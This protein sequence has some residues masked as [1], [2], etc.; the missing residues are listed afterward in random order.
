MKRYSSQNT[1]QVLKGWKITSD[2]C[3]KNQSA[4][5]MLY[6]DFLCMCWIGMEFILFK[7]SMS[8]SEILP[9]LCE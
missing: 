8:L 1:S 9:S 4:F 3:L 6:L 7:L 2:Q 5:E